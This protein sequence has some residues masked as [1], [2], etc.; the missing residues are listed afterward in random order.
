V[1]KILLVS[2]VVSTFIL[3][4]IGASIGFDTS[5]IFLVAILMLELVMV[6]GA[7]SW[8]RIYICSST[9]QSTS[10]ISIVL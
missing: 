4:E 2:F 1:I 5:E 8:V 10:L 7:H 6:F 9:N 3:D